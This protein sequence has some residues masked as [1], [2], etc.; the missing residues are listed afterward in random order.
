MR[1]L[2]KISK[3]GLTTIPA[4]IKNLLGVEEG[5]YL[6]WEVAGDKVV[7]SLIK[8]PYKFLKGRHEDPGLIYEKVEE[9]ADRLMM[10]EL[11]AGNR[12]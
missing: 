1:E 4:K 12:A 2:S 7:V 9:N 5:D 11:N 6:S 10:G 8:N 3:K